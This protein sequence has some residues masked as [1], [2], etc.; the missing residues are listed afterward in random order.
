MIKKKLFSVACAAAL[1]LSVPIAS[2]T[3]I[4]LT[5]PN[6]NEYGGSSAPD[7]GVVIERGVFIT[8]LETFSISSLGIEAD[9]LQTTLT[10]VANI[11]AATNLDR[12]GLLAT[13][14]TILGDLGS[15]FYDVPIN[16][17]L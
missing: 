3:L 6:P 17:V 15:T 1:S 12:G 7:S 14:S 2:A 4:T 9:L 11:Y 5:P 10:F 16:L 8:A 13:S